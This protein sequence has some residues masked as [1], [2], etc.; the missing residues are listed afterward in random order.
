M[1]DFVWKAA[2]ADGSVVD[3]ATEAPAQAQILR[4]LKAQGLTPIW[5]RERE[6]AAPVAAAAALPATAMPSRRRGLRGRDD[7]EPNAADV[8]ALTSELSIMLKAGLALDTALRLLVGMTHKPRMMAIVTQV[9]EDVKGGAPLSRAL[10]RHRELFG[11]FYIN[12]VRSGEASGQLASVFERLVEHIER[13]RALRESVISAAI[14][15]AILLGV[16]ILSLAAMLG[17]VVPQFETLFK[18]MG[19]ALPAPTRFVMVLGQVFTQYG[20]AL[21][22]GA[23]AVFW[24]MRRWARSPRGRAALQRRA[25]Q[26][27]VLGPLLHQYDLTL[28]ARSLGTLLGNGV[29]LIAALNIATETVGNVNLRTALAGVPAQ[30]KDGTKLVDALS[31]TGIFEPLAVNLIRVGEETGRIGPML[32]ELAHIYNRNVE[33]GIKRALTMLEPLLILVLGL[34][35]AAIIVSILLGI[36]SVNDLAS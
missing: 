34:L 20:W 16:A 3:G 29:P 22:V 32:L 21:A 10:G 24:L 26:L 9:L 27:P 17:F 18:D 11:D 4:Q 8:L 7:T 36:L 6:G 1:P 5:V 13:L 23:A 14:Y 33:T 19:D 31:V 28:F 15:P 25:L 12:M 30:V 35:I 2:R